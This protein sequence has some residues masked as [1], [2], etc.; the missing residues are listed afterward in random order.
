MASRQ[1]RADRSRSAV[2]CA[3]WE[4]RAVPY[5]RIRPRVAVSASAH[6]AR[7]AVH[8]DAAARSAAAPVYRARNHNSPAQ[9]PPVHDPRPVVVHR[10]LS[11]SANRGKRVPTSNSVTVT[12]P[13]TAFRASP[14]QSVDVTTTGP[15]VL[16]GP[17]RPR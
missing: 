4:A 7:R 9:N 5:Q 1:V 16:A 11:G 13:I 8:R 2:A 17:V 3:S 12:R 6:G 14:A 10:P 15:R